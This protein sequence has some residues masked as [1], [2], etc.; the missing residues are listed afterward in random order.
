MPQSPKRS[1][2]ERFANVLEASSPSAVAEYLTPQAEVFLQGAPSSMSAARF[3]TYIDQLKRG[4]QAFHTASPIFLTET[5]A[6]WLTDI[7]YLRNS[8]SDQPLAD[9]P[10]RS[11]WMEITIQDGLISR[12]WIHFTVES[13]VAIQQQPDTY[14]A[15]MAARG[16]PV[17]DGWIDGTAALLA[18]AELVDRQVDP[19][20]KDLGPDQFVWVM[21]VVGGLVVLLVTIFGRTLRARQTTGRSEKEHRVYLRQLALIQ[22]KT[23]LHAD[24]VSHQAATSVAPEYVSAD[25]LHPHDVALRK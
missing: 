17:P 10:Q 16:L 23:H 7:R 9:P 12:V 19:E 4:H 13:L 1:V 20:A 22:Q 2:A 5:G 8:V 6:G 21:P 25:G 15:S 11:L 3:E 24:A 14:R 18:H